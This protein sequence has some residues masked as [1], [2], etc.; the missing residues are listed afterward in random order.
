MDTLGLETLLR[1]GVRLVRREYQVGYS[2]KTTPVDEA[3][4]L[5]A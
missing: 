4:G 1:A 5:Y 2:C 3:L